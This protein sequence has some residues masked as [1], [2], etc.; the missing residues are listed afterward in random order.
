[1]VAASIRNWYS[2]V[3]ICALM[4]PAIAQVGRPVSMA[5]YERAQKL[6]PENADRLVLHAVEKVTWL[7]SGRFWYRTRT[8]HGT[9]AFVVDPVSGSRQVAF[10]EQAILLSL[11]EAQ[12]HGTISDNLEFG[13]GEKSVTAEIDGQR[14]QCDTKGKRCTPLAASNSGAM[15]SPDKSKAIFVRD[16][17]LWM[18]EVATGKEVPLTTDGTRDFAYAVDNVGSMRTD[19]AVVL[20]SPDSRHVATFQQDLRGVGDMYLVP[21]TTGHPQVDAWKYPIAGD[22]VIP[23]I[24]RVIVDTRTRTMVRLKMPPDLSRSPSGSSLARL[25]TRELEAQ[26]SP[27]G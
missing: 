24:H 26:W 13:A 27:D 1:M 18:L 14:W 21:P 9:R 25:I 7:S 22:A 12:G 6:L 16:F 19:K 5:D 15:L 3:L 2:L 4:P 11:R 20:W 8:E 17:N 23:A 10:D